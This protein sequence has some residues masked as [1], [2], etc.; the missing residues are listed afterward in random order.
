MLSCN[1]AD[2]FV[3]CRLLATRNSSNEREKAHVQ[4][5]RQRIIPDNER[6]SFS[7]ICQRWRRSIR[8]LCEQQVR[9]EAIKGPAHK[10]STQISSA[11]NFFIRSQFS[12]LVYNVLNANVLQLERSVLFCLVFYMIL[13][14]HR[15]CCEC[16]WLNA[17]DERIS[18]RK[19]ENSEKITTATAE[20]VNEFQKK[21]VLLERTL[22]RAASWDHSYSIANEQLNLMNEL[23]LLY[24]QMQSIRLDEYVRRLLKWG[25]FN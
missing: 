25:E 3:G 8:A 10:R 22:I 9:K 21:T 14:A 5:R 13:T 4:M 11:Q 16:E 20:I 24:A 17:N 2:N 1:W 15:M 18:P 7:G 19:N 6:L 12:L 23:D